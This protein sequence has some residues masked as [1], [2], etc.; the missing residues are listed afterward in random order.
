MTSDS[1]KILDNPVWHALQT[2]HKNFAFGAD[3]IARYRPETLQI[4]GCENPEKVDLNALRPW[5][6]TGEKLFMVGKLAAPAPGWTIGRKLDCIQMVCENAEKLIHKPIEEILTLTEDDRA[7]MLELINEV[8]P[9]Y[10]YKDTPL[11][12]S[13]FG[14]RKDKKLV[15]MA[16]ERLRMTGFS[17]ISAVA[18]HP[19]HTGKGYAKMLVSHVAKNN[20]E[21]GIIPFLHFVN[22]NTRAGKVYELLGFKGRRVMPFWELIVE[23]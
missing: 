18:T 15:A 12:G 19:L 1:Y 3:N 16:G 14:I 8:Q 21:A 10:F 4:L 5:I 6:S 11:L 23:S 2:V 20:M 22:T 7:E 13:Y 9:G 17:E